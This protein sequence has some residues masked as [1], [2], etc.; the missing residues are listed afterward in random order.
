[1]TLQCRFESCSRYQTKQKKKKMTSLKKKTWN[2]NNFPTKILIKNINFYFLL[3]LNA[4]PDNNSWWELL[5]KYFQIWP[6]F[7]W[8]SSLSTLILIYWLSG[9]YYNKYL[10]QKGGWMDTKTRIFMIILDLLL[11]FSLGIYYM[12]YRDTFI[13]AV[14]LKCP[15]F[16]SPIFWFIELICFYL[17]SKYILEKNHS[18]K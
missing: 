5:L 13:G 16:C 9:Y 6:V 3:I 10:S 12:S 17:Y 4:T 14:M 7:Q 8:V 15:V 18:I 2:Q 11:N 1:M